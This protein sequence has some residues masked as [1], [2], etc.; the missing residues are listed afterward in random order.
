MPHSLSLRFT[1]ERFDYRGELP[2]TFNAGNR[3]YGR[4]VAEWLAGGLSGAGFPAIFLDE[5]WGWLVTAAAGAE[6]PFEIAVYNLAE[7]GEGGRPGIGE[8]GLV[9]RAYERRKWLGFL[10]KNVE[11]TMPGALGGAVRSVFAAAGIALEPW[12]NGPG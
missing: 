12:A 5:D 8:W 2:E 6:A 4:D 9:V 11:V 7:H 10:A 3:F 1:T